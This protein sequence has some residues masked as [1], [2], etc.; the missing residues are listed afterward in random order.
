MISAAQ[1]P[2]PPISATNRPP[3]RSAALTREITADGSRVIQCRAELDTTASY[4]SPVVKSCASPTA[5][6]RF[7]CSERAVLTIST[8]P[9]M[10]RTSA[11]R[12]AISTVIVPVP[13]PRSMTRS[14][15]LGSSRSIS[16]APW[17]DT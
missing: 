9:S 10:P 5:N 11:P 14:S 1:L 7:G 6:D 8:D 3:G 12:A 16:G 2:A 13:Q 17:A 4:C 15:G